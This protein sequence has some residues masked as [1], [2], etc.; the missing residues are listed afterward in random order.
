MENND[1]NVNLTHKIGVISPI[2]Q[3]LIRILN[4]IQFI[5]TSIFT[6]A[7][8]CGAFVMGSESSPDKLLVMGCIIGIFASPVV[9][10]ALRRTIDYILHL[11]EGFTKN[12]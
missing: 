1:L 3:F 4:V 11:P 12:L 6:I 8:L 5:L 10:H 7:S 9:I 2:K